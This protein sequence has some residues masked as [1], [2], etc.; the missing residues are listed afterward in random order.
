[1][2]ITMHLC[3]VVMILA[4]LFCSCTVAKDDGKGE[5]VRIT[6]S[7]DT[8]K[9]ELSVDIDN[10]S[11]HGIEADIASVS[12]EQADENGDFSTTI[13]KMSQFSNRLSIDKGKTGTASISLSRE[14][15]TTLETD[16]VY[17]LT[18]PYYRNDNDG[19][20]SDI[21]KTVIMHNFTPRKMTDAQKAGNNAA[22]CEDIR[23]TWS[24]D[25]EKNEVGAL[26]ENHSAHDIEI[27]FTFVPWVDRVEADG[28]YTQLIDGA[29]VFTSF[30]TVKSGE[31]STETASLD[32]YK[33]EQLESGKTYR[34]SFTYTYN[35]DT[36]TIHTA[37]AA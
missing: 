29:N 31:N 24:Y 4:I 33:V 20:V 11:S 2:K 34:F 30:R 12:L 25:A 7:Y 8:D 3:S 36:T 6:W 18:L 9:N 10:R 22:L 26:I 27:P 28:K 13:E 19:T 23:I 5:D 32:F 35:N 16:T 15:I 17:R 1:M 21:N 14:G 37:F